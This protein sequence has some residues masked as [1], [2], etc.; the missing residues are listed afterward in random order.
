MKIGRFKPGTFPT[1]HDEGWRKK[2]MTRIGRTK[3]IAGALAMIADAFPESTPRESDELLWESAVEFCAAM[4]R[5]AWF[6]SRGR[7]GGLVI[8]CDAILQ[9]IYASL[10][11][12]PDRLRAES[13]K[14]EGIECEF[15][16][17]RKASNGTGARPKDQPQSSP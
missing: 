13:R 4:D 11:S 16:P 10:H 3:A 8:C 7:W 2:T 14:N 9:H 17:P 6:R 1:A 15:D 12:P 5:Y